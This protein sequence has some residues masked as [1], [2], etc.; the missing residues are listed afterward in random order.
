MPNEECA[1]IMVVGAQ[2]REIRQAGAICLSHGAAGIEVL[3]VAS[4]RN[5]RWGLPKGHINA[6]ESTSRAAEREAFEEAGVIGDLTYD[7]FGEFTYTKDSSPH[8]YQVT[9]HL[10]TVNFTAD[11]YPENGARAKRWFPL[12][13][14]VREVA[15]PGVRRL[16]EELVK[17]EAYCGLLSRDR[18]TMPRPARYAPSAIAAI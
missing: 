18:K 14:A 7:E 5:G 11:E 6:G 4:R 15:Q 2:P 13:V 8:L 17:L 10:L 1:P 3:L 9:A 16:L 12:D